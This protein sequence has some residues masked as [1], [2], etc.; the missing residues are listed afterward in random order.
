M[1]CAETTVGC[2]KKQL[3]EADQ[4]APLL[5]SYTTAQV[6]AALNCHPESVRLA[7]R[8]G[9]IKG[10]HLGGRWRVS[11]EELDRIVKDGIPA[12]ATAAINK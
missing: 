2:M 12:M 4:N 9:R 10:V 3:F 1:R 6:G 7:C 5:K 8:Q 11:H